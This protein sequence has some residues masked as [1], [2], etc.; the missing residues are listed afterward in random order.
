MVMIHLVNFFDFVLQRRARRR[1]QRR[2]GRTGSRRH[3]LVAIDTGFDSGIVWRVQFAHF[4]I[5][6]T[7]VDTSGAASGSCTVGARRRF[8]NPQQGT[9]GIHFFA[10]AGHGRGAVFGRAAKSATM[11]QKRSGASSNG[12]QQRQV[13]RAFDSGWADGFGTAARH[14]AH[15]AFGSFFVVIVPRT[16]WRRRSLL[17]MVVVVLLLLLLLLLFRHFEGQQLFRMKRIERAQI[18]DFAQQFQEESGFVRM[19]LI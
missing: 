13:A 10:I 16:G 8:D 18:G 19:G 1:A 2:V 17:M 4:R 14:G 9:A 11:R 6:A 3:F 5:R 12:G 15:W 7:A